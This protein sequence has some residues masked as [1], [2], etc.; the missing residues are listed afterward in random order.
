MPVG[1]SAQAAAISAPRTRA[2]ATA[3]SAVSTPASAAA[4]SSPT[5][6]PATDRVGGWP[7]AA[8]AGRGDQRGGHQ[9]RL[10]DGGVADLVRVRGGAQPDQVEPG[11]RGQPAQPVGARRAG[12][13]TGPACRASGRP[14]RGRGGRAHPYR[15]AA[16]GDRTRATGTHRVAG[17]S[18]VGILQFRGVSRRLEAAAAWT[19]SLPAL[20]ARPS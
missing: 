11:D 14:G 2:S 5:L 12:P 1:A 6:W 8:R 9:Q 4:T 17:A 3:A 7:A 16:P 13:A 15:R 10:G 18:F 19:S 20:V